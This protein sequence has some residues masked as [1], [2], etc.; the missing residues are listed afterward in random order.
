M[1]LRVATQGDKILA[2][3]NKLVRIFSLLQIYYCDCEGGV[4]VIG[5]RPGQWPVTVPASLECTVAP[6]REAGPWVGY[7]I[8][9][10]RLALHAIKWTWHLLVIAVLYE[11]CFASERAWQ[12][13]ELRSSWRGFDLCVLLQTK[14]C[15]LSPYLFGCPTFWSRPTQI[16]MII[17]S[18]T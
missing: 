17:L 4:C 10:T 3:L 12:M 13:P 6:Q 1:L 11:Q 18:C 15:L 5:C 9:S 14:R 2:L 7:T 8:K 16:V